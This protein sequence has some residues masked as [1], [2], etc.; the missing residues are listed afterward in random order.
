MK[1]ENEKIHNYIGRN[2]LIIED[3]INDF[4]NYIYTI[5]RNSYISL[6]DEDI[7]EIVMDVVFAVWKNQNK[8]DNNKKMSSYVAGITKNLIKKKYRDK[9]IIDNIDDYEEQ[10]VSLND[11]EIEFIEK[12]ISKEILEQIEN[13]KVDDK[14]I[15]IKYYYEKMSIKEISSSL[16]MTESKVKSKLFRIRKKLKKHLK[17]GG[18]S[19]NDK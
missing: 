5:S 16:Y 9:K 14:N 3:V 19:S 15:F 4:S 10:L 13:L 12:E 8:L 18:Y 6:A 2:G 7:E 17:K 1:V 11:I